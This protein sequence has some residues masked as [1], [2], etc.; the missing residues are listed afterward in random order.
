MPVE[1]RGFGQVGNGLL[2]GFPEFLVEIYFQ[3]QARFDDL[4]LEC[5]L[6]PVIRGCHGM[7]Q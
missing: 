6:F 1:F 7:R 2:A 5:Q 4:A 3:F